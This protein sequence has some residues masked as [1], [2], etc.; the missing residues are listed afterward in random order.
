MIENETIDVTKLEL[1][2]QK[3]KLKAFVLDDILISIIT[4]MILWDQIS[5]AGSDLT[6]ILILM[7]E[8]F[9]QVLFLKLVY[10]TFFIWYYGA[11]IG[12]IVFKIKVIKEDS[13]SKVDLMSALMRSAGRIVSE[14]LFYIGFALSFYTEGRQTLH[15]KLAKTLVVNA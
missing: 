14:S 3:T 11:T 9:I 4:M 7:N 15:D 10:Q 12:K 13:F 5:L 8:A 1:A 2:T 6:A